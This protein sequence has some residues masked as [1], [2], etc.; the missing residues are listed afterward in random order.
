MTK[1]HTVRSWAHLFDAI[2]A[3]HKTHD[4]RIN[5]RGYQVGDVLR[6]VRYDN[7]RGRDGEETLDVRVTYITGRDAVPCAVSSAVLPND[8]VILSIQRV[9]ADVSAA[10]RDTE[11]GESRE[12]T[13][14]FGVALANL[15][16]TLKTHP[17]GGS[18]LAKWDEDRGTDWFTGTLSGRK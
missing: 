5:D 8:Y 6:L 2:K 4:L 14:D 3:G 11:T 17:F 15:I 7:V 13:G 18:V 12:V 16:R 9:D 10:P 1:I